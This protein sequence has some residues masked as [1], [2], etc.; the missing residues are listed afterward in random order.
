MTSQQAA[1]EDD[2][3]AQYK[4]VADQYHTF[5][6]RIAWDWLCGGNRHFG[7]YENTNTW[8]PFP[9]S[10]AQKRMQAKLLSR[11]EP[12]PQ[13]ARVLDIGCGDGHV[14][15]D[16]ALRRPDIHITGFDV[17]E[18]HL[19]NARRNVI[20]EGLEGRVEIMRLD[21][22]GMDTVLEKNSFDAAYTSEVLL[23]ASHP[24]K[25]LH[26]VFCVL[27]SPS[28]REGGNRNGG[29]LVLHEYHN[30]F[31]KGLEGFPAAI[32]AD[33]QQSEGQGRGQGQS[34]SEGEEQGQGQRGREP[35]FTRASRYFSK[36]MQRAG[37]QEVEIKDYSENVEPMARL[38]NV[39]A[40][41]RYV[42]VA[43]RLGRWF[44]NSAK[45][46]E[47]YVGRAHW[48]YVSVRGVKG[49]VGGDI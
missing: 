23:H 45:R 43:L 34:Q 40:L 28:P 35:A 17:V 15:I 2:P 1:P 18:R 20:R 37:F 4:E 32:A 46:E 9:I 25:V 12:L 19:E 39:S 22:A 42:V 29:V 49:E 30:D 27:K 33:F 6:S 13:D 48:A 16:L 21:F 11:L 10:A 47:G 3:F 7:Y 24:E 36:E 38:L 5:E 8:W 14:A 41:W 44:P 26:T 31:M